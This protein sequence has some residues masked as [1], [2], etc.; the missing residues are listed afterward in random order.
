MRE[1]QGGNFPPIKRATL[2]PVEICVVS[3]KRKPVLQ[4]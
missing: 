1:K 2:I 3:F 4:I